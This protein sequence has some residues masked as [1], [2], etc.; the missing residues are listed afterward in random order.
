MFHAAPDKKQSVQSEIQ[1]TVD[2]TGEL[3]GV[4]L[5]QADLQTNVS[6]R[7]ALQAHLASTE[8][9]RMAV[10]RLPVALYTTDAEG[11][12]VFYNEAATKLWGRRPKLRE[13]F[14]CGSLRCFWPDGRLMS[15]EEYPI[16][17][18]IRLARTDRNAELVI[19]RPDGS[20]IPILAMPTPLFD[21]FG[22]LI[23]AENVLL[24]ISSRKQAEEASDLLAA[25]V[26]S[27]EDAIVSKDLNGTVKSWNE[28]ACRIFGYAA[29]EIV[30]KSILM[31]IPGDRQNEET[32][33]LDRIRR[34]E[35]IVGFE[36]VRRHKDGSNVDV[37]L[38]VSPVRNAYGQI[39]G[40]SKIARDIADR[41][42]T[43]REK[44]LLV[45]EIKHR[46]KNTL[47]SVQAMA[48]Q[49]LGKTPAAERRAFSARLQA[50]AEA[51]DL[52]TQR[53]WTSADLGTS[54]E[55]AVRPFTKGKGHVAMEGPAVEL[56]A[57]QALAVAMVLHELATNAAKYGAL[58]TST[59]SLDISWQRTD[60]SSGS[61]VT[62]NWRETGGPPV[63][64]PS[65]RGFGSKLIEQAVKGIGG[66]VQLRYDPEGLRCSLR[67]TLSG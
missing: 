34:G 44:E 67:I 33:I 26:H 64:P 61:T 25:V 56:P 21:S 14:W 38:T 19:E 16:T 63:R 43:E 42:R 41:K 18:A 5:G 28:A 6:D 24:D 12:I 54:V 59:G 22:E 9:F 31:I 65:R 4:P 3:R 39:I 60:D 66:S 50:L 13:E 57:N 27:A 23:G 36:T 2:P 40:A 7:E 52:L 49:T 30:G 8:Y 58:S 62:L 45:D 47:A 10:E 17:Q 20:R 51:H 1:A 35:R 15:P 55:C 29:E 37:S 46:V 48:N 11:R 53:R 32:R